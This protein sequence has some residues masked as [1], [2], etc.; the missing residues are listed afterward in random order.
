MKREEFLNII[1]SDMNTVETWTV[2]ETDTETD[3]QT[4]IALFDDEEAAREH[5]LQ[6]ARPGIEVEVEHLSF[7]GCGC[8]GG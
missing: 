7:A 2:V 1:L 8:G 3:R 4:V 6:L 5:A